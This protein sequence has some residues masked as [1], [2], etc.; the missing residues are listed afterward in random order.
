MLRP[1]TIA[2]AYFAVEGV[3]RGL[4]AFISGE[5]LPTLPLALVAAVHQ[6]LSEQRAE[7]SLGRRVPDEIEVVNSPDIK[8]RIR[9]CRPKSSWDER[10]TIFHRDNLYEVAGREDGQSPRKFVC[11]LRSRPGNKVVRGR[12]HYD[13]NE[14]VLG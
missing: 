10:I 3:V 1:L 9:S 11:T 8:L 2:L 6:K 12:R 14:V 4:A 5:V 13:P 7:R